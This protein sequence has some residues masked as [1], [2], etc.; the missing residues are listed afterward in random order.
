MTK[1]IY[2]PFILVLLL[3]G[4][5]A[6]YKKITNNDYSSKDPFYNTLISEY[7]KMADFEASEMHD[8]NS[9]KLYS[10]KV[11]KASKEK[12]IKPEEISK[13]NI[14][15]DNSEL[16]KAYD[17][18]ILIYEKAIKQNPLNLAKAIVSLDCWAEQKEE[19]W[20]L[21]HIEKCKH[22]Y[23]QAM[24]LI[25]DDIT[26]D[27]KKNI[28]DDSALIITKKN[29]ELDK[30]IYF[31][32]D[33]YNLS[34]E[35]IIEL[36]EFFSKIDINKYQYFIIGHTDTKGMKDY[37]YQ[38]SLFRANSV[39]DFLI[40]INVNKDKIKV[41]GRGENNLA[42]PTPDETKHPANRRVEIRGSY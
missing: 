31:D 33:N 1:F 32:F 41:V 12:P 13:W 40:S 38:L 26:K 23:L 36:K 20:Q 3:S 5:S 24:H 37:N 19:G 11:I 15:K 8:W 17:N 27:S 16:N 34:S 6:D 39:K 2:F 42:I 28:S 21:D 18:L 25:Y 9:A 10:Q 4:C 14:K 22:D 30:I 35:N 7:K 29:D